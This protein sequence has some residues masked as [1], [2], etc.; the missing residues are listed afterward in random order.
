MPW[1]RI[2]RFVEVFMAYGVMECAD[3]VATD[4]SPI[5]ACLAVTQ[6]VSDVSTDLPAITNNPAEPDC[7]LC[8]DAQ[9]LQLKL[10]R[11]ANAPPCWWGVAV[12]EV[13]TRNGD[14]L[15]TGCESV[16]R[17]VRSRLSSL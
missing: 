12:S 16:T 9:Q 17:P 8:D 6:N 4:L 13:Q 5:T 3:Y 14:P 1:H 2:A 11:E 10:V 7:Q 15:S